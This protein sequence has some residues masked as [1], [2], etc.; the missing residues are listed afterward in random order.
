MTG[1]TAVVF[2]LMSSYLLVKPFDNPI[3]MYSTKPKKGGRITP[4]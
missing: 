3:V 2:L 4:S 1:T